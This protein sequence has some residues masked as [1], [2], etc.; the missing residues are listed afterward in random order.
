[1][2]GVGHRLES[3]KTHLVLSKYSSS[4][5]DKLPH[6]PISANNGAQ[7][8]LLAVTGSF[9]AC[10]FGAILMVEWS[11]LSVF[12]EAEIPLNYYI[13]FKPSLV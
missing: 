7:N 2:E 3:G 10:I 6:K 13:G 4:L 11:I 9:S 1:M 8:L 12:R 5:G